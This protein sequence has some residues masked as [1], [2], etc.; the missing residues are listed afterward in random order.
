MHW[1]G[2][3]VTI[4]CVHLH[5]SFHPAAA[6]SGGAISSQQLSRITVSASTF[7]TNHAMDGATIGLKDNSSAVLEAGVRLLGNVAEKSGGGLAAEGSTQVGLQQTV[8]TWGGWQGGVAKHVA[9][10]CSVRRGFPAAAHTNRA[11]S[12]FS[13]ATSLQMPSSIVCTHVYSHLLCCEEQQHLPMR[14]H[15]RKD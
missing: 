11:A 1:A 10:N 6:E 14:P 8:E 5:L 3:H 13:Q 15:E 7:S 12:A 2:H 4:C 9:A